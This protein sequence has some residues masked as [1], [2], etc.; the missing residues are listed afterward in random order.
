MKENASLQTGESAGTVRQSLPDPPKHILVVDD[1]SDTRQL[2]I[3]VLAGSGY[4]V[5]GVMD[6]AAGWDALQTYDYDLVITDN[7]MPRMTGIEMIGKL[8]SAN[9]AV[10]VIMA[11]RYLPTHEFA[12]RPWLKPDA[13]LERPFSNDELLETVKKVLGTVGG[14]GWAEKWERGRNAHGT[15]APRFRVE[16]SPAVRGGK[17]WHPDPGLRHG[18]HQ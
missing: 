8:R 12:R 6:G 1:D 9:I 15:C 11:T 14:R 10:P 16:L 3:D 5:E 7:K 17:G 4:D 2:S 18:T 13:A